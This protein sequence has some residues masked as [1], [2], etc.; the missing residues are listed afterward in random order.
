MSIGRVTH[1]QLLT[2]GERW[3]GSV[4]S[5]RG[6]ATVEIS[7]FAQGDLGAAVGEISA[8]LWEEWSLNVPLDWAETTPG[9][10]TA[11]VP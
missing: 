9:I 10:W 2:N 6:E 8:Y 11:L 4:G 1:V 7:D 3:S 5:S